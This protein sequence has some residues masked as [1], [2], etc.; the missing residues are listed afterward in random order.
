MDNA[1]KVENLTKC[2][3]DLLA[4]DHIS[5]VE[6]C[7]AGDEPAQSPVGPGCA[8]DGRSVSPAVGQAAPAEPEAGVLNLNDRKEL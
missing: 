8:A 7:A 5:F 1:I 2:Y 3:R 6:P 4:V